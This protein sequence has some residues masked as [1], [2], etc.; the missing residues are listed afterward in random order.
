MNDEWTT[1]GA[2]RDGAVFETESGIRAMKTE[3]I[4]ARG[5]V[6]CYLLA[7]GEAAWFDQPEYRAAA[8]NRT[9]VR[10]IPI[11]TRASIVGGPIEMRDYD[12][13]TLA[14]EHRLEYPADSL[15]FP[16]RLPAGTRLHMSKPEPG[17]LGLTYET[18][19]ACKAGDWPDGAPR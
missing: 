17:A 18:G 6:C 11:D 2:L 1:L 3:Y 7:S 9:R 8:H 13:I 10:E 4:S 5:A 19:A 14:R 12:H 16:T 15:G